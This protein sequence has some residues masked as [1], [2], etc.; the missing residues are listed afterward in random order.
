[1]PAHH[2][3]LSCFSEVGSQ[4]EWPEAAH[5]S[6]STVDVLGAQARATIPGVCSVGGQ[7][8]GLVSVR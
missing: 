5:P 2:L 1:M 4:D 3:T 6:A 8:Q 7:N